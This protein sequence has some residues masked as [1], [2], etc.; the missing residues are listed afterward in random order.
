MCLSQKE[1]FKGKR[2][3]CQ[4]YAFGP[5]VSVSY[6]HSSHTVHQ[7]TLGCSREQGTL[8]CFYIPTV[9]LDTVKCQTLCELPL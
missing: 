8:G 6:A 3:L 4:V 5:L 2:G 7:G 9:F 1:E